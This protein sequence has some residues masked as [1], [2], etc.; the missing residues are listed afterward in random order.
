MRIAI[1]KP[2][3]P[4]PPIQGT[5]RVTLLLLEA[6]AG[7]HEVTMFAPF[8]SAE[9]E[10]A[11]R[12]LERRTG[13]R[14]IGVPAPNRRSPWHRAFYKAFYL[15]RSV[16]GRHSPRVLYASPDELVARVADFA[17]AAPIDLAIF[18]YWYTYRFRAA[19]PARRR[20]L[21]AHD[22]EFEVNRLAGGS[23]RAWAAVEAQREAEACRS[24]DRVW[25]LT[26]HDRTALARLSGRPERDFD[27]MP[28]GVDVERL[29]LDPATAAADRVLFFGAFQADFNVDALR[30][31]LE[32]IWPRVRTIRPSAQL[33]VA[34]GGLTA[35]LARR[36]RQ[37]GGETVGPVEELRDL[38]ASSGVVVIPL[39]FGG[40]LRI[41]LL[42]SLAAGRAVVAT[43]IGAGDV[44]G[45]AGRDFVVAESPDDLARNI[46]ELLADPARRE[47]LGRA[48]Q[49]LV[50]AHYSESAARAGILRLARACVDSS[51]AV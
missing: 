22:A 2:I 34:G 44:Q 14:V 41:R 23:Q 9:D 33:V 4:W 15:A 18:E 11:A 26:A 36:I 17:A 8:Q 21:L 38:Y 27:Q 31:L 30:Y 1:V 35:D 28:F 40:G 51:L 48:G 49:A 45:V 29:A 39:R 16:S 19:L 20:V 3:V 32:S 6:L 43:P 12:V 7:E 47:G 10:A 42:E 46:V 25:T 5:R 37:A 24:V 50:R 13:C